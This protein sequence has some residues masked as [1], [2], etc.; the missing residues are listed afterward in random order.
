MSLTKCTGVAGWLKRDFITDGMDR[1]IRHPNYLGEMLI[2]GSFALMVWHWLPFIVLAWIWGGLFAV[3]MTIKEARM[4]RYGEWGGRAT[5]KLFLR[6]IDEPT[7]GR[8]ANHTLLHQQS[9][10]RRPYE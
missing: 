8:T 2:Y 9:G 10:G 4:S 5:S 6:R 7:C 1:Y 3:N